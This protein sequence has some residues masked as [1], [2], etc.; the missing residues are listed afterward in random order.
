MSRWPLAA[1]YYVVVVIVDRSGLQKRP[2][3]LLTAFEL[4]IMS[5]CYAY[6]AWFYCPVAFAVAAFFFLAEELLFGLLVC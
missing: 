2:V 6:C 5:L 1:V 4:C 3:V